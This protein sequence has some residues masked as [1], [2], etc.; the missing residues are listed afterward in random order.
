MI[1]ALAFPKFLISGEY[2]VD[3]VAANGDGS[4][5][6][7]FNKISAALALAQGGDV[8][9]VKPGSYSESIQTVKNAIAGQRIIIQAR[10]ANNRPVFRSSG[11]V[12]EIGHSHV[13]VDGLVIDGQFGNGDVVKITGGGNNAIIRNCEIK[14]GV[15]DGVDLGAADDVLIE[16]CQIHHLLGGSLNNQV[17][18]HGIVAAGQKNLTIRG[19]EIYYVS[20]DCFQTDP[21]RGNPLWDNVLIENSRL[22]TGPLP[23]EAAGWRAGEIPGENAVDT[24]INPEAAGSDYRARITIR[25]VEAFGFTPGFISN[26]AAFNIKE[27][28]ECRLIAVKVHDNEIAFRLRGPGDSGGAHVTVINAIV[29]NNEKTFRSEDGLE[30]LR[31]YNCTF[32]K[33]PEAVYFQNVSGGF[34]ANGF[35]L[36]NS[37]FFGDLPGEAL[38][39]SNLAADDTFFLNRSGNDYRLSSNSPAIDAGADIAEVTDDFDGAPRPAGRYDV[40]AYEYNSASGVGETPATGVNRF[41]L[42]PNFPNPFNPETHITFD[43]TRSGFVQLHIFDS[44]GRKVITLLNGLLSAGQHIIKWNGVDQRGNEVASG[45]YLCRLEVGQF[46]QTRK[47]QLL[48]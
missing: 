8:V 31:I 14:N 38:Q 5:S 46:T 19:C 10:E 4:E 33:R 48:R 2:Y 20:G 41:Y 34:D 43:M 11:T 47:M 21:N 27:K 9:W 6:N 24:K 25:N 18:A 29:Y 45:L 15:K 42:H 1:L 16:N 40:G 23:Q 35:D 36:K 7:P 3:D 13:T 30:Q 26:R 44:L 17:D 12:L 39:A 32:D 28:V 37:L 22:W